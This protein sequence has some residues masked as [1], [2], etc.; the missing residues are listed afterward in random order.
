M[1]DIKT[2]NLKRN[3]S[4]INKIITK[5]DTQINYVISGS[6]SLAFQGVDIIPNDVDIF[7]DKFGVDYFY[8]ILKDYSIDSPQIKDTDI[9]TSYYTKYII[10]DVQVEIIGDFRTKKNDGTYSEP[11]IDFS[12]LEYKE[13][14]G[15]LI[16]IMS[17][18]KELHGYVLL[19]RTEKVQKI[20]NAIDKNI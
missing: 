16:P 12:N 8:S 17:L 3:L 18:E 13:Y 11:T 19:N 14:Q 2:D 7:T 20:K 9:A 10:D 6:T 1:K 15:T 5:I 4:V